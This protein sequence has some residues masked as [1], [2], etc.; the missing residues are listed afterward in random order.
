[1][2]F[3]KKKSGKSK[4][5][6][7]HQPDLAAQ[8]ARSDAI[9]DIQANAPPPP[10]LIDGV[11]P[12]RLARVD[13]TATAVPTSRAQNAVTGGR[14]DRKRPASTREEDGSSPPVKKQR[15]AR[16]L[17]KLKGP[18]ALQKEEE[19]Q[20]RREAAEKSGSTPMKS[21]G[22][23]PTN[24]KVNGNNLDSQSADQNISNGAA[25]PKRTAEEKEARKA[26]KVA[27]KAGI[28]IDP[29]HLGGIAK[30]ST[31]NLSSE[32]D[33]IARNLENVHE[34]EALDE[35]AAKK[36]AKKAEKKAAKKA[37]RNGATAT[38]DQDV[39]AD[40]VASL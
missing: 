8:K 6:K 4:T 31:T 36:A 15:S 3:H 29:K 33:S 27:K 25:K 37:A 22:E 26:A 23:I 32:K 16:S 12:S 18:K 24:H 20:A 7:S 13:P 40:K 10:E 5:S 11:H 28:Q 30:D 19:K 21:D 9:A 2:G 1:M 38:R 35:S 14:N 17:L 39:P 34:A